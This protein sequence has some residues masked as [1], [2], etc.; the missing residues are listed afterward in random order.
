LIFIK[1]R[2]QCSEADMLTVIIDMSKPQLWKRQA[3]IITVKYNHFFV[4]YI[5]NDSV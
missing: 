5:S 2:L 4:S 3:S 1:Y